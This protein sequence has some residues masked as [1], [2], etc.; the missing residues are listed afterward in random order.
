[1]PHRLQQTAWRA[2]APEV[3]ASDV[4]PVTTAPTAMHTIGPGGCANRPVR[5]TGIP[6]VSGA[7]A[8]Y[9]PEDV[10]QMIVRNLQPNTTTAAR[11]STKSGSRIKERK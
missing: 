3:R 11:Q 7:S 8:C 6:Q 10:E 5:L 4:V 2:P 9:R 1:M